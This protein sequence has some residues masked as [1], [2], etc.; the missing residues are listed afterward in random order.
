MS[1]W[2]ISEDMPEEAD[3]EEVAE[4][5]FGEDEDIIDDITDVEE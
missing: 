4:S 1:I 5:L 3:V 2:E